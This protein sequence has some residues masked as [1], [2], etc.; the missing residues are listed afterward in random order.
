MTV[1]PAAP[2]DLVDPFRRLVLSMSYAD[3]DVRPLLDLEGLK[4]WCDGRTSGYG[5][6]EGAVD[7]LAFYD[8]VGNVTASA[9]RP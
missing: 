4:A 2:A 5:P 8:G 9:Y 1:G 7:A 3:P 6:L